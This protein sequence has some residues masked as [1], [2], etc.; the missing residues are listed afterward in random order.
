MPLIVSSISLPI[1]AQDD[2]AIYEAMRLSRVSSQDVSNSCIVKKAVDARKNDNIRFV[3]TVALDLLVDEEQVAKKANRETVRYKNKSS[4]EIT[5]TKK[6]FQ[7]PVVVGFGPAGMFAAYI[8]AKYGYRPI[9]IERGADVETRVK[10]VEGFWR[11]AVLKKDSNVQFGEGGA[12]TFSDGKLTTRISDEYCDFVLQT[13][14]E[15]GAPKEILYKAK[16]HIGTDNLRKVVKLIREK[17]IELGGEVR[18]NTKMTDVIIKDSVVEA[19]M[20]NNGIIETND[21][22]MAIGHSAR[23]TFKMLVDKGVLLEPKP[24]SVGVRA[25]HL[26]EDINKGLYGKRYDDPRLPKGEYQLSYRNGNRAVYTFCMCP[27]GF[28]VPSSSE[29]GSVV[30]NGMSEY[31]RNGKNANSAVVVSVDPSDYGNSPMDAI[32]FQQNLERIAFK[33]G[34]SNYSAPA[35]TLDAFFDKSKNLN[36]NRVEPTYSIGTAPADFNKIFPKYVTE[37]LQTGFRFFDRRIKGFSAKD[38][39]ITGVETRTSSPVRITRN[40]NYEAVGIR[41]L[42]PCAEGAGYAGGIVSAAVDGIRVAKAVI[43]G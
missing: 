11:G 33:E 32:I 27:G 43:G 17:I 26:Q 28:V 12:G 18:F 38:T 19:V 40:Q 30:T 16:P 8:L 31:S 1:S 5:P 3:Y 36:I 20:T 37:M 34:G 4:F 25:E 15:N 2:D 9:I 22:I 35:Q 24:F 23:D 41:G 42:Y 39:V 14:V 21:V 29:E 6:L 13:F 7:R 10:D